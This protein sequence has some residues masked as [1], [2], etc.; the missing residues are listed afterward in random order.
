MSVAQKNGP[1][2]SK[3]ISLEHDK[4]RRVIFRI[5]GSPEA[6]PEDQIKIAYARMAYLRPFRRTGGSGGIL[7]GF[8]YWRL[9]NQL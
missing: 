1:I 4:V 5:S 9:K 6:L 8:D 3:S 2:C 7:R